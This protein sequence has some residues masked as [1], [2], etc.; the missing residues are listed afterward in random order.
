M[1]N[2][3]RLNVS[4]TIKGDSVYLYD[5][6]GRKYLGTLSGIAVCGLGHAHPEL[7]KLLTNQAK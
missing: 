3:R 1:G 2:I 4:F 5:N 6:K 7:V